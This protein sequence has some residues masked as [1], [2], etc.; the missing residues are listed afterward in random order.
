M[1]GPEALPAPSR[2]AAGPGRGGAGSRAGRGGLRAP[3]RAWAAHLAPG[4]L[5]GLLVLC[6]AGI[7]SASPA[8]NPARRVT[9]ADGAW[10]LSA[11]EDLYDPS[12][13]LFQKGYGFLL[14]GSEAELFGPAPADG[15]GPE[16]GQNTGQNTGRVPEQ[17]AALDPTFAARL[18]PRMPDRMR[19]A[20]PPA[21]G[22]SAAGGGADG[23]ED[24]DDIDPA[25]ADLPP[26]LRRARILAALAA[27]IAAETA[28]AAGADPLARNA[29][30]AV[31]HLRA[32]LALAPGNVYA[33]NALANAELLRGDAPAAWTA[34]RRSWSLAPYSRPVAFERLRLAS[35]LSLLPRAGP[36]PT[37]ADLDAMTADIAVGLHFDRWYYRAWVQP[38]LAPL[39]Q[40]L[41]TLLRAAPDPASDP[42]LTPSG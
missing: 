30:R 3:P 17:D 13:Y 22:G 6:L 29:D 38:G 23:A 19:A 8:L 31:T 37:P 24:P 42:A 41:D 34:L 18:A 33:W 36:G 4:G 27:E 40:G 25:D 16:T 9:G 39:L 28:G 1:P 14:A 10:Q 7:F 15:Q 32:S 5:L 20:G 11:Q 21:V 35:R 2:R 26:E 12:A